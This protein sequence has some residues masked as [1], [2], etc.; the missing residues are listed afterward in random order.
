ME[1]VATSS[2][3]H[4]AAAPFKAGRLARA[5]Y[6]LGV[7]QK[8]AKTMRPVKYELVRSGATVLILGLRLR[9]ASNQ[10]YSPEMIGDITEVSVK[11]LEIADF[12]EII[13]LYNENVWCV[14]FDLSCQSPGTCFSFL[15]W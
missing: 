10:C 5:L 11:A 7:Y 4:V 1:T 3:Y 14:E 8:S 9:K 2:L 15:S 6:T 12:I 13:L